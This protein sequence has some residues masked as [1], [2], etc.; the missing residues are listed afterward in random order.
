MFSKAKS[1]V[2]GKSG[3]TIV[4]DTLSTAAGVLIATYAME[5]VPKAVGG[6]KNFVSGLF[7][8][9]EAKKKAA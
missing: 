1:M 6:A 5:Y 2:T 8:K 9:K 4:R 7:S 3:E